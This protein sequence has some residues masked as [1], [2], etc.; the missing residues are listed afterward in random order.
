MRIS[1]KQEADIQI[2]GKRK[3]IE[4]LSGKDITA[5]ELI[6]NKVFA[7]FL[8]EFKRYFSILRYGELPCK[9][10]DEALDFINEWLPKT[11]VRMENSSIDKNSY[12]EYKN[13][14]PMTD[15]LVRRVLCRNNK[16][17]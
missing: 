9:Q 4:V 15:C 10:F 11:A 16:C 12:L 3:V 1:G 2:V 17:Y 8:L 14:Q 6:S 13:R 7:N 5:Y